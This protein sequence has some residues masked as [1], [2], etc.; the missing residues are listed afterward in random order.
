MSS[1]H[2]TSATADQQPWMGSELCLSQ[3]GCGCVAE[4]TEVGTTVNS[5][6]AG[7]LEAV[8]LELTHGRL[9]GSRA[10]RST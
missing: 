9:P 7:F 6:A 2:P 4:G 3:E 10:E 8:V 1:V 5:P